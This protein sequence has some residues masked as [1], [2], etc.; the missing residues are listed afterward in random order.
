M[1]FGL[2]KR[3]LGGDGG[4]ASFSQCGEDRIVR[5]VMRALKV[6]SPTYLD[7]GAHD[8]VRLSNTYLFYRKGCRG[9][10]VEPNPVR[11]D[12]FVRKRPGDVCLNVGVGPERRASVPFYVTVPD[13]L[14]T[15]S[16]PELERMEREEGVRTAEVREVEIVTPQ[17]LLARFDGV[18]DFVSLDVEGLELDI[19]RGFDLARNRPEVFCVET[20]S[21]ATDGSGIKNTEIIDFLKTQDYMM[22][23]DTYINTIFVDRERW[24]RRG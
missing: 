17:D 15:F 5:F 16:K 14:S 23:A 21:Y 9:V 10:C 2:L 18:P 20:I 6:P 13:T 11:F 12:A 19:L 3:W 22:Y 7:I 1:S 4:N 24:T 8:P